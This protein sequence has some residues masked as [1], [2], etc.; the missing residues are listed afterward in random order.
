MEH[1]PPELLPTCPVCG[2]SEF[3]PALSVVD[4][5]VS[6]EVFHLVDCI[7]CGF[8]ITNPRP[9][10]SEIARY[11]E[12]PDYISHTNSKRT[13]ADRIYQV[14]RRITI[15]RKGQLVSKHTRRG[16]ALDIGCGT[17]EFLA[18]LKFLG[19]D[20]VGIEPSPIARRQ[21]QERGL[22]VFDDLGTL[23][24]SR[25]FDAITL[26]HVL[27]HFHHPENAVAMI[28]ELLSPTGRLFIAVPDREGWDC[29]HYG[30]MWAAWD[31]PRHLSHFRSQDIEKL[32]WRHGLHLV[33][34][35]RMWFDAPYVS[36]LSERHRSQGKAAALFRGI[37]VG[38]WSN[39]L[40]VVTRRPT[41]STLFI[42]KRRIS[43]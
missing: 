38:S 30:A 14:V 26:W 15:R 22:T 23:S 16:H 18:H 9:S 17:G 41:S 1:P 10:P 28:N 35:R 32:L 25:Q 5:S 40:S 4:H 34:R 37:V 13:L 21:A 39:L 8:R 20:T 11:Y 27:E 36:M 6:R 31:V 29:D 42:A 24:P 7:S 19:Y 33:E 2:G 12:S 3:L 43:L